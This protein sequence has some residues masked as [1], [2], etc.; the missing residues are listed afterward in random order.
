MTT[1]PPKRKMPWWVGLLIAFGVMALL[2]V[3][4]LGGIVWWFASNKDRLLLEGKEAMAEG[5]AF[6]ASHDQ[7]ACVDEALRK[8]AACSGI[9]CEVEAKFFTTACIQRAQPTPG[10]C[11][12]VPPKNEIMK[13]ASWCAHECER[14]GKRGNE[15]CGRIVQAVPEACHG[16]LRTQ[17]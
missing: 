6:A 2:G 7:S 14:R 1:A 9:M 8:G 11:D 17:P 13:T 10:F 15:R 4:V 3:A 12:G 5:Q 16:A